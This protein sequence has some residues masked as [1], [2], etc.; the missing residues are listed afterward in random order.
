MSDP[1]DGYVDIV[2]A[3]LDQCSKHVKRLAYCHDHLGRV[4]FGTAMPKC[5]SLIQERILFMKRYRLDERVHKSSTSVVY[6]A[7]DCEGATYESQEKP[8]AL[9][10]ISRRDHFDRE[11]AAHG[12][13]QQQE[14][15]GFVLRLLQHYNGD[16]DAEFRECAEACGLGRFCV[17]LERAEK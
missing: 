4:V 9:K 8:V 7:S 11:V 13:F 12:R 2:G 15:R 16:D 6:F 1:E 17:V 3:I 5:R 14:S 10:F